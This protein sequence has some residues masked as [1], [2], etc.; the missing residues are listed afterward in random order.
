MSD[1]PIHDGP[2]LVLFD[3]DRIR[4]YVFR[5][6]RLKEI[7]GGSLLVRDLTDKE[8]LVE[9]GLATDDQLVF[10]RGGSGL[11]VFDDPEQAEIFARELAAR[12]R[13]ET[14][15]ATLTAVCVPAT[16]NFGERVREGER[17]LRAAKAARHQRR[18]LATGPYVRFCDSCARAPAE[19]L[20][21]RDDPPS[22]LCAICHAKRERQ[23]RYGGETPRFAET[24]YGTQFIQSITDPQIRKAWEQALIPRELSELGAVSRTPRPYLGFIYADGNH[25]GEKRRQLNTR[26]AFQE[27]SAAIQSATRD[28]IVTAL[29]KWFP[30]PRSLPDDPSRRVAPFDLILIGGDD[31]IL[32]TAADR[33]I[34]VA[35]TFAREF[36]RLAAARGHPVTTSVGVVLSHPTQPIVTLEQRT[37]ELVARAKRYADA[38]RA[39]TDGQ[40]VSAI[41]FLVAA[42]ATLNPVKDIMH[43]DY[44]ERDP[45]RVRATLRPYT[46]DEMERLLE[47]V[48]AFHRGDETQALPRNKLNAIYEAI[49]IGRDQA[50]FEGLTMRWRLTDEQRAKVDAFQRDF[51]GEPADFPWGRDV[52]G[53][54]SAFTDLVEL[55]P[56][57][58]PPPEEDSHA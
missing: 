1:A 34:E 24:E 38:V 26:E 57:S 56:F 43:D 4:D 25:M 17:K 13:Q 3:A 9:R 42:T 32:I 40:E 50:I 44:G 28:A 49:R 5:T 16:G 8:H 36:Q 18:Q 33:A 31:L 21:T 53:P 14:H 29:R 19:R 47:H 30:T 39:N 22:R 6:G 12:Y 48:W 58:R 15:G 45:E 35:H 54:G 51:G 10:A 23:D 7:R 46:V 27:F 11:A 55:Y 41:N 37:H 2:T 20:Y 52:E